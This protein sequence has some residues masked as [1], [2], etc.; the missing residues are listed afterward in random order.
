MLIIKTKVDNSEINGMGLFTEEY[1]EKGQIISD[2]D[3]LWI[4]IDTYNKLPSKEWVDK[5]AT[6]EYIGYMNEPVF[7]LD[8]D[9]MRYMNHSDDPNVMF[10]G[11]MAV[12]TRALYKGEELT[13]DYRKITTNEHFKKL[14][15]V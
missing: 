6:I 10:I 8:K 7:I 5:Y 3:Y 14:M 2:N 11:D 9:N 12:T 4:N 13:Y 1:L 15:E